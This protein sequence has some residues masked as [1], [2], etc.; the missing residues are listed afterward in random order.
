MTKYIGEICR[1]DESGNDIA[2]DRIEFKNRIYQDACDEFRNNIMN[3]NF[4][5]YPD[6]E[7]IMK[8]YSVLGQ[9]KMED[10]NISPD[11]FWVKN[12]NLWN[13]K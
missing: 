13:G 9:G 5:G 2:L 7:Y 11:S 3:R 12:G 8:L 10:V 1:I 4:A 6:G